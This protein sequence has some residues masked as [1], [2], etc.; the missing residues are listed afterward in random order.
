MNSIKAIP[1]LEKQDSITAIKH[2]DKNHPSFKE[3]LANMLNEVNDLQVEAKQTTENFLNGEISDVHQVMIAGEKASISL[4]LTIAIRNKL[5]D[6]YQQ[7][8]RMSG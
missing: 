2:D 6:A 4:Q 1:G 5:Y 8:M 3:T 7:I